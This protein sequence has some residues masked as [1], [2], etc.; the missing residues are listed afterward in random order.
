MLSPESNRNLVAL[1]L[2]V[3][4]SIALLALVIGVEANIVLNRAQLSENTTQLLTAAFSGIIGGLAGFLGGRGYGTI[5]SD[6]RT[7]GPTDR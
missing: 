3:G 4:V 7:Q 2:A 5:A 6:E 1:V